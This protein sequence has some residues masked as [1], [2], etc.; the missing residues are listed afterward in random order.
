MAERGKAEES[1]HTE[2]PTLVSDAEMQEVLDHLQSVF[3]DSVRV[4]FNLQVPAA[5]PPY[6]D[7][8]VKAKPVQAK[9]TAEQVRIETVQPDIS[10]SDEPVERDDAY[11]DEVRQAVGPGA[12]SVLVGTSTKSLERNV[13]RLKALQ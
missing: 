5:G 11:Y 12:P 4:Q 7:V 10:E 3:G 1:Q 2:R 8:L 13:E 9:G 6:V